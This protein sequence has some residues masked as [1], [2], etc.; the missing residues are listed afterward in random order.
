MS[1]LKPLMSPSKILCAL[2]FAALLQAPV[3]DRA[4]AWGAGGGAGPATKPAAKNDD[5][6]TPYKPKKMTQQDRGALDRMLSRMRKYSQWGGKEGPPDGLKREALRLLDSLDTRGYDT[7]PEY[8][9]YVLEIK[10]Y[11]AGVPSDEQIGMPAPASHHFTP[12][13]AGP[14]SLAPPPE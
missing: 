4:F 9:K 12:F 5:T 1:T 7:D 6:P 11:I 14:G 8:E 13:S 3:V 2:S 10:R